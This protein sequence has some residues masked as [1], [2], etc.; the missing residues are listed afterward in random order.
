M[1]QQIEEE[2]SQVNTDP[3]GVETEAGVIL[4]LSKICVQPLFLLNIVLS[5][6]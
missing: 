6:F 2:A 4:D 5:V 1:E 3:E